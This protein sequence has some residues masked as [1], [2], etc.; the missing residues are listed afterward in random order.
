MVTKSEG[1][2]EGKK[3]KTR[4]QDE[5]YWMLKK[6]MDKK[7]TSLEQKETKKQVRLKDSGNGF[8]FNPN[9]Y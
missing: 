9:G 2:G 8:W 3:A 5:I 1:G 4:E 6:Q 7:E